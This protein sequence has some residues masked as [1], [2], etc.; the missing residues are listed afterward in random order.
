[1]R[2][3]FQQVT[4]KVQ[5]KCKIIW[6]CQK[7]VVPLHSLSPKKLGLPKRAQAKMIFERM[8]IHNKM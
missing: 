2:T 7:F 4:K 1:M 5:K 8:S 6:S 3:D